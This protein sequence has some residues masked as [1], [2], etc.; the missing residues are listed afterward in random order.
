VRAAA[1]RRSAAQRDARAR[2]APASRAAR[3]GLASLLVKGAAHV[4][5]EVHALRV[6]EL[7]P[8]EGGALARR[9][10]ELTAARNATRL[11][12]RLVPVPGRPD[13]VQVDMA[14]NTATVLGERP[15]WVAQLFAEDLEALKAA[16]KSAMPNM[17]GIGN[18]FD[19]LMK[20]ADEWAKQSEANAKAVQAAFGSQVADRIKGFAS[21]VGD[22]FADLALDGENNFKA[23]AKSF[24]KMLISMFATKLL[25]QPL[26]DS[27]GSAF[28][29][30]ISRTSWGGG[31]GGGTPVPGGST[32]IGPMPQGSVGG[33]SMG[34][35]G[36]VTVNV[37]DQ[38]GNGAPVQVTERQ[39]ANGKMI[40]ILVRDSVKKLIRN[41]ELDRDMRV[42]YGA[43]RSGAV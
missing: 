1:A 14:V 6:A 34:R 41:G 22:A 4:R 32:F 29:D 9:Y 37:I 15:K 7:L 10:R 43:G 33:L 26:F 18:K 40:D 13:D 24:E 31:G 19:D 17:D 28:G 2:N 36:G 8:G 3:D 27:L 42:A 12:T 23:L 25:F 30:G 5:V 38:R 11:L 20:R 35:A 39:G 21:S 16:I